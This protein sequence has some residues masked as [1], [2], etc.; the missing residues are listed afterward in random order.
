MNK[1]KVILILMIC[2]CVS[3]NKANAQ[4]IQFKDVENHWAEK[5]ILELANKNIVNGY[6]DDT[7][8]PEENVN[9]VEFLK[10]IIEAG[11]YELVRDGKKIYPDFYIATAKKEKIVNEEIDF[12]KPLTRYEMVEI[13]SNFVRLNDVK[14]NKNIFKDIKDIDE[15][16]KNNILKLAKLGVINGYQDKTFKGYNNITRAES[17]KVIL[18]AMNVKKELVSKRSYKVEEEKEL[19]NY[20]NEKTSSIKTFYEISNDR[21]KIYDYGRYA[22][23]DGYE[24]SNT[25]IDIKKIIKI[26][27]KLINESAYVAVTYVPSKYTIN[28]LKILYGTNENKVLCGEYDFAFN[29]YENDLYNLSSK[30]LNDE[31]SDNCYLRIDVIKLWDDYEEYK[32][33][34]Y[35]DKYKKAKLDEALK[36]EFG[37]SSEKISKYIIEKNINYVTNA[38]TNEEIVDKKVVGKYIVNFYQKVDGVPQFYIERK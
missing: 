10:M 30:S 9:I 29:Y 12:E 28:E 27:K 2:L 17:T 13:I 21:L 33:G 15:E 38:T 11:N 31:F 8:K 6:E 23:L 18:A 32:N 37:S 4:E 25:Q 35:V 36:I 24:V 16:R 3:F 1:K 20:L 7:F 19:S 34:I 22:S 5:Y 14:A 26:I